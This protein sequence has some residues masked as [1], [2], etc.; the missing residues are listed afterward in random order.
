MTGRSLGIDP[1]SHR[2]GVAVSDATGTIASPL[3]FVAT[4]TDVMAGLRVICDE[5][6]ITTIVIGLPISLDGSEGPSAAAA[7]E[8]GDEIAEK[9]GLPVEYRDERFTSHTAESALIKGGVR[10]KKRKE[11][12]D[13]VAAAVML[14]GWLDRKQHH[15]G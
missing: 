6:E 10:R 15:D 12:R 13:Q 7:R 2:I 14:Q 1:G 5:Y 9:I 3:Q 8:L 11:K 4:D